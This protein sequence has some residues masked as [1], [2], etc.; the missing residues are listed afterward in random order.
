MEKQ[1][2]INFTAAAASGNLDSIKGAYR[3]MFRRNLDKGMKPTDAAREAGKEYRRTFGATPTKRWAKARKMA[4]GRAKGGKLQL[5]G[6]GTFSV[7]K[8]AAPKKQAAAGHGS[9]IVKKGKQKTGRE[10][11]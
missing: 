11:K 1:T 6:L 3:K 2:K 7:A 8:A 4:S 5:I 10:K 9:F